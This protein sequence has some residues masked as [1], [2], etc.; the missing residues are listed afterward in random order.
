[1]L[2]FLHGLFVLGVVL[3]D[4]RDKQVGV[5]NELS[6]EDHEF[7]AGRSNV[8]LVV[9]QLQVSI[10]LSERADLVLQLLGETSNLLVKLNSADLLSS[11]TIVFR[12]VV[13]DASQ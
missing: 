1:M 13:H 10:V 9:E 5:L 7:L 12:L 11:G 4:V 3:L 2:D 8:D 6:H